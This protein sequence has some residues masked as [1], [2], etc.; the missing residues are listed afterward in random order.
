MKTA[1]IGHMLFLIMIVVF[2]LLTPFSHAVSQTQAIDS[3][4]YTHLV[5]Q[6]KVQ[7]TEMVTDPSGKR[8]MQATVAEPDGSNAQV[9]RITLPDKDKT[10]GTSNENGPLVLSHSSSIMSELAVIFLPMLIGY[11]IWIA[12]VIFFCVLGLRLVRAVERIAVNTKK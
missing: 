4:E 1:C 3:R 12:T 2:I 11:V 7:K 9:V 5:Q 10:S 6:G 8:Y